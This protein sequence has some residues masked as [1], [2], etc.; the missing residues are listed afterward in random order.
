[1]EWWHGGSR[2][3]VEAQKW[4]MN[5]SI[6]AWDYELTWTRISKFFSGEGGGGFVR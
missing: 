5:A 4:W 1:V 3:D 2:R 6:L